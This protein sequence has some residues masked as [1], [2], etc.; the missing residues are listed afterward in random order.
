MNGRTRCA[1]TVQGR[2]LPG[3]MHA[4]EER[5]KGEKRREEAQR[6]NAMRRTVKT[7]SEAGER[8]GVKRVQ[9][10]ERVQK[11]HQVDSRERG[12]GSRGPEAVRQTGRKRAAEVPPNGFQ[13][14]NVPGKRNV[15]AKT[16][17]NQTHRHQQNNAAEKRQI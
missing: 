10:S 12:S 15:V 8:T 14:E 16:V 7:S 5:Q 11:R 1:G 3:N 13:R 4:E 17:T 9:Q 6:G 2:D